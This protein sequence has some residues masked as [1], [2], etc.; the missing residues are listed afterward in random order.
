MSKAQPQKKVA[1][2]KDETFTCTDC[3]YWCGRCTQNQPNRIAKSDACTRF[4]NKTAIVTTASSNQKHGMF[5]SEPFPRSS[6]LNNH[7]ASPVSAF[8]SVVCFA[9]A[10]EGDLYA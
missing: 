7:A 3:Q 10:D 2:L 8:S 9:V 1:A 4:T 5:P 6:W